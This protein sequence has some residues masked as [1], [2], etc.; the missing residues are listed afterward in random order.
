MSETEFIKMLD[1]QATSQ[2][3][4][5]KELF[6]LKKQYPVH[7][8]TSLQEYL[9]EHQ[10][11]GILDDDRLEMCYL[12]IGQDIEKMISQGWLRVVEYQDN[13]VK[14]QGA[15]KKRVLFAADLKSGVEVQLQPKCHSY[16]ANLWANQLQSNISWEQIIQDTPG[17]LS[18]KE[19]EIFVT[20][21]SRNQAKL[22]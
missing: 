19:R 1:Q 12:G 22:D 17:L 3:E 9:L 8:R 11:Y 7:D 10:R 14:K 15:D 4:Y 18:D 2:I 6:L 20:R 5:T 13:N 16:L 21:Q